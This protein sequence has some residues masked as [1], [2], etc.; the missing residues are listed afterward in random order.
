[1]PY[2]KPNN[3]TL[4]IHRKSNHPPAILKHIPEAINKR[5]SSLSQ[6]ENAFNKAK[7]VYQEALKKSGYEYG[8]QFTPTSTRQAR[9]NKLRPQRKRNIIWYNPPFSKNVSTNIGRTFLKI[10]DE[11][12]PKDHA[13]HKIFNRNTVKISYGCMTN[14]QQI[15]SA[16]NKSKLADTTKIKASSGCNCKDPSCCPLPGNCKAESIIYQATVSSD[17]GKPQT[18]IGLTEGTFK[19]RYNNHKSSFNCKS[20]KYSTKLSEYIWDL[21]E[22]NVNYSVSW[23]VIKKA[24]SFNP[25]S[26]R[27]N[28]CNWEKFFI[29]CKPHMASLNKRN[30]LS[31]SCRHSKKFLLRNVKPPELGTT[32]GLISLQELA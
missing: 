31:T 20:K 8:L 13:L 11:E 14:L 9:T 3:T 22:N 29:I 6:D 1:M 2:S 26:N 10:L 16:H 17:D 24:K 4:Y 18:Y 7:P 25:A 5:L 15:V 28:L 12:F 32:I 30:E 23:K 21:K 19:S 27:C